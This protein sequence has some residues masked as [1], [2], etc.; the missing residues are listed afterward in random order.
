MR[1][2]TCFMLAYV[3]LGIQLGMGEFVRV[4]GATPSLVLLVV[5]FLAM[6]APRDAALL[7]CFIIGALQDM[8]T[9][10]PLGLYALSYSVVGMFVVSTQ[11]IL[12]SDH[13]VTHLSVAFV[14]GLVTGSIILLHG[15]IRGPA[16]PVGGLFASALYTAFL[17]PIVLGL[18][19]KT[20]KLFKFSRRRLRMA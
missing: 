6:N 19:A 9:L 2:I 4:H 11:E 10:A 12:H 18:L 20:K 14:G 1:W 7:A 13:P 8:T 3:A 16:V 15:W 5:I 17:A